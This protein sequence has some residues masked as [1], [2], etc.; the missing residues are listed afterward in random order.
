[1]AAQEPD[2]RRRSEYGGLAIVFA[3]AAGRQ[4]VWKEALKGWNVRDSQQ[5][6]EWIDEG[7]VLGEANAL[8]RVL[9][10]RYPPGAPAEVA[11]AIRATKDLQRL[12][13]WFDLAWTADSLEAFR[14][15]AGI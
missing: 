3:E 14:Q 2:A 6:Q 10:K 7:V 5:V 4:A 1:L 15:A 11:A 13:Q 9:A 8:L 12:Q